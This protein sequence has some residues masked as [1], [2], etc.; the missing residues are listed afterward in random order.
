MLVSSENIGRIYDPLLSEARTN[1]M[2]SL[3]TNATRTKFS[4]VRSNVLIRQPYENADLYLCYWDVKNRIYLSC[5]HFLIVQYALY[6]VLYV[7]EKPNAC[8]I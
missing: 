6:L 5:V 8:F 2:H 3:D 7:I 4:F 1:Y